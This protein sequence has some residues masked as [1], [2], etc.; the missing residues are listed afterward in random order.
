MTGNEGRRK[1][2]LAGASCLFHPLLS[3]AAGRKR[4]FSFG[5]CDWSLRQQYL[6]EA[7][8]VAREIGLDG[9]Q[10]SFGK[11]DVPY[12]LRREENR[13]LY[14]ETAQKCQVAIASLAMGILNEKPYASDAESESWVA[15]CIQVMVAMKQKVVLLAFFGKGDLKDK[16]RE[17]AE[18]VRR[19][20]KVAPLAEKAG[21]ILAIESWLPAEDHLRLLDAI[22]SP[23]IRV[24]YDP[25]NMAEQGYDI[26]QDMRRLGKDRIAE[27]H[28]K[29][30]GYL[31]GQ[32]R[33]DWK[34]F[35]AVL[36]DMGWGGWLVLEGALV[37]EKPLVECY[38]HNLGYLRSLFP[39]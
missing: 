33:L 37:K 11:K 30:N 28:I 36:D 7:L 3:L 20:K 32:G 12:D 16:P 8:A 19:L 15:E 34:R 27:I 10:V 9:V 35:Q 5:A 23:A 14:R 22:G 1:V 39:A 38:R 18:V 6:P 25:C 13:R 17:Q 4:A 24:Y 26:F 2:L 29:E 21:V 31:L